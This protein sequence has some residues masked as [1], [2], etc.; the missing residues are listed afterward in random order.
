VDHVQR[1]MGLLLDGIMGQGK[2]AKAQH[3]IPESTGGAQN[4][5]MISHSAVCTSKILPSYC[6]LLFFAQLCTARHFFPVNTHGPI[7]SPFH[8]AV[9]QP[10]SPLGQR[11]LPPR[12][13]SL[14][15]TPE[16]PI[17]PQ[18]PTLDTFKR[19]PPNGVGKTPDSF[20]VAANGARRARSDRRDLSMTMWAAELVSL[21]KSPNPLEHATTI[22]L[23]VCIS[24]IIAPIEGQFQPLCSVQRLGYMRGGRA[25][26][27]RDGP[28]SC[29][30]VLG[31]ARFR[32]MF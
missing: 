21:L 13:T 1:H 4:W 28:R 5:Q 20:Q 19:Y 9:L 24:T 7:P 29:V 16:V 11:S 26:R 25:G 23:Y 12:K 31:C 27:E 18:R 3:M 32:A 30:F 6:S 22:C 2:D 15:I 8:T 17:P 14:S 10:T